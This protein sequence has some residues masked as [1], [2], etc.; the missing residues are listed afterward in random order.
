[1]KSSSKETLL[2]GVMGLAIGDA[3]GVPYE[4]K[5]REDVKRAHLRNMVGYGTHRQEKGTWSDD[6][7]LTLATMAGMSGNIP[8]LGR[9]MDNFVAWYKDAKF[10]AGGVVFDVGGITANA[11]N[12]YLMGEDIDSCGEDYEYSNGNGSLMRMLPV[13]YDLWQRK[14]FV[15]DSYV[16][17]T[18]GKFSALTH[19]HPISKEACVFYT[20]VAMSVLENRSITHQK[21]ITLGVQAVEEYYA[22]SGGS[23]LLAMREVDSLMER[24][25]APESSIKSTGF[26]VDGLEASLWSLYGAKSFIEAITRAVGLGGD[27]D[28]IGAITGSL[29]GLYGGISDIPKDWMKDLK[30]KELIEEVTAD[31]YRSYN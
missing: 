15:I 8:S 11:I 26:V 10:T 12:N 13:A 6:T 24:V 16:V 19:A 7:S 2:A 31:F 21:A 5:R 3:V 18:V 30:N 17:E 1:M 9:V 4:F 22:K 29:A 27:T 23:I 20:G 28:T 25:K 14:G